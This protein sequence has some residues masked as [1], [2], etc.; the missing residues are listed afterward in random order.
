MDLTSLFTNAVGFG[1]LCCKQ[2]ANM[3]RYAILSGSDQ[4]DNEGLVG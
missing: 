4:F 3:Q 1:D 2:H